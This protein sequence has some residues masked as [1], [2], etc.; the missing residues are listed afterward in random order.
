MSYI[1]NNEL[2]G[3]YYYH[4]HVH[5]SSCAPKSNYSLLNA[6]TLS[7]AISEAKRLLGKTNVTGCSKCTR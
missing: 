5:G 7:A 1:V 6:T 2:D 3:D 4:V